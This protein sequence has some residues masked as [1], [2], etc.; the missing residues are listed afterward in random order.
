[1][2]ARGVVKDINRLYPL[3]R[4][5]MIY[6]YRNKQNEVGFTTL[7]RNLTDGW[8]M[9]HLSGSETVGV[10]AGTMLT[11]FLCF[12]VDTKETSRADTMHLVNTIEEMNV[13]RE[14]IHVSLSG[15]KG[16]H[17]EIFFD[18]PITVESIE[19]FYRRVLE[20]S[21]FSITE[22]ELRPLTNM[23]VKLPL[24]IH[25]KTRRR[26]WFVDNQTF[27]PIKSYQYLRDVE[28]INK[29]EF[30][31]EQCEEY[32]EEFMTKYRV[33]PEQANE[34]VSIV[35][36][37]NLDEV[38]RQ[39]IRGTL[40]SI[41][42]EGTL[43]Y[44]NTR[45]DYTLYLAMYMRDMGNDLLVTEKMILD[46]MYNTLEQKPGYIKS[47]INH[48]KRETSKIVRF[49]Y[50][51]GYTFNRR[52]LDVR[53]YKEEM[54]NVLN[55]QSMPLKKLYLSM[56]IHKK[57]VVKEGDKEFYMAY[58]V[59]TRLG[60]TG[61]RSRLL[62][63]VDEL[64]AL[65]MVDVVSRGVKATDGEGLG[66][67]NEFYKS[68]FYKMKKISNLNGDYVQIRDDEDTFDIEIRLVNA[69]HELFEL[70]ELKSRLRPSQFAKIGKL[71]NNE[72][73]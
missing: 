64:S 35:K 34:T 15:N 33:T 6:Q 47:N 30:V 49:T 19:I 37:L 46:I 28:P 54:E 17:V 62:N 3:Y 55:L 66:G 73:S 24:G 72:P 50:E 59:M 61:N 63:Y 18:S 39:G 13:S 43:R 20:E 21:G 65:G 9:R 23:G 8:L 29:D 4:K 1:M 57:Q 70:E 36:N 42:V 25:Q 31:S 38:A 67:G 48:I 53:I 71:L 12:D 68:N 22:V 27:N 10:F 14:D 41:L 52:A 58:S 69:L 2:L 56:L 40:N 7:Q 11:K 60:N 32:K 45:N 44:P 16:Y 51:K 5:K 26:C